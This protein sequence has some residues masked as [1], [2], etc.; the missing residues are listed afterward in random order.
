[1]SIEN[2]CCSLE[3][4]K[5]LKK[6]GFKKESLFSFFID[7]QFEKPYILQTEFYQHLSNVHIYSAFTAS[8]LINILPCSLE[9]EKEKYFLNISK[10]NISYKSS[11][12]SFEYED[13]I[14]YDCIEDKSLENSLAQLLIYIIEQKL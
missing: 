14:P 2:I 7:K 9:Y 3:Y 11:Y 10:I 5:K 12:V 6:I 8:E 4:A 1:M 13:E